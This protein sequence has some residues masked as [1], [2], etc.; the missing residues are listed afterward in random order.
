M[1]IVCEDDISFVTLCFNHAACFKVLFKYLFTV[2]FQ[3][4]NLRNMSLL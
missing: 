3:T 2:K 1:L 4:E